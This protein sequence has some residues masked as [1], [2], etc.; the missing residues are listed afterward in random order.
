M[1]KAVFQDRAAALEP[2]AHRGGGQPQGWVSSDVW[3]RLIHL[4]SG[5]VGNIFR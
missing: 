3:T 4:C 1:V 2:R 5:T